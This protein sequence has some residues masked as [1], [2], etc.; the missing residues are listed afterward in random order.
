MM[1]PV[2]MEVFKGYHA[3][4]GSASVCNRSLSRPPCARA[5]TRPPALVNRR[6]ATEL[7][8]AVETSSI[9]VITHVD[10]KGYALSLVELEISH[11]YRAK[12]AAPRGV[13]VA[14]QREL[15]ERSSAIPYRVRVGGGGA[16]VHGAIQKIK[17][18][19][20]KIYSDIPFRRCEVASSR[21]VH[22]L[23]GPVAVERLLTSALDGKC[24]EVSQQPPGA[25]SRKSHVNVIMQVVRPRR[26]HN[27][28]GTMEIINHVVYTRPRAVGGGARAPG[29]RQVRA[30]RLRCSVKRKITLIKRQNIISYTHRGVTGRYRPRRKEVRSFVTPPYFLLARLRVMS[31]HRC[32]RSPECREVEYNICVQSGR[33]SASLA[34]LR[35]HKTKWS[36]SLRSRHIVDLALS[37]SDQ[38]LRSPGPARIPS[39]AIPDR[40]SAQPSPSSSTSSPQF[41]RPKTCADFNQPKNQAQAD[42]EWGVDGCG[43]M[44]VG[45]QK[46]LMELGIN[47]LGEAREILY[48]IEIEDTE[49]DI[50]SQ[51]FPCLI[52]N[53]SALD[54]ESGSSYDDSEFSDDD[55]AEYLVTSAK[56]KIQQ[57]LSNDEELP[58]Q[59][60]ASARFM[61]AEMD[62]DH[63]KLLSGDVNFKW[64]RDFTAFTAVRESFVHPVGAV[65]DYDSPY[66][67]FIDIFDV[68]IMKEI[69]IETNRYAHQI[70]INNRCRTRK[71]KQLPVTNQLLTV[72]SC[73]PIIERK[74][75]PHSEKYTR[76][77]KRDEENCEKGTIIACHSGDVMVLAGCK[78]LSM[79][80]TFHDNS[81]YTGTS[82]G[83]ECYFTKFVIRE[84]FAIKTPR[85]LCGRKS[86]GGSDARARAAASPGV[87]HSEAMLT[88]KF[89]DANINSDGEFEAAKL[90]FG[91]CKINEQHRRLAR[92]ALAASPRL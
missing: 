17:N 43:R 31:G 38:S 41:K 22:S 85:E 1:E 35:Y 75:T 13:K 27:G 79:I 53:R 50:K 59:V 65:K 48:V 77:C 37:E 84:R 34:P 58:P 57:N 44:H 10:A 18:L 32:S 12:G 51:D 52:T 49:H 91:T 54:P 4:R 29:R 9:D 3:S 7:S 70:M 83:E 55:D 21:W 82:A 30:D 64:Q 60:A 66:D 6:S 45:H 86:G 23:R 40:S 88:V 71:S 14:A 87:I 11:K 78:I 74:V 26:A 90:E 39:P 62:V 5:V 56:K 73:L 89:M 36:T 63:E 47:K 24:C 28:C 2:N 33:S 72:S 76:R 69:V 42:S 25:N 8:E 81:T 20:V 80:S 15:A 16:L 19:L 46:L 92:R 67:A 68:D 61:E